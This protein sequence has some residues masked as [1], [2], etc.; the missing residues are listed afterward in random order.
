[1]GGG[2][3]LPDDP[4]GFATRG[5]PVRRGATLLF[6][7]GVD[8]VR[9]Q[10]RAS[11]PTA[12]SRPPDG[13]PGRGC[14]GDQVPGPDLG[15]DPGIGLWA[16]AR[17][18]WRATGTGGSW[19]ALRAGRG[20]GDAGPWL[21]EERGRHRQP[22]VS[23]RLHGL[24]GGRHWDPASATPSWASAA[25]G[26]KP[27]EAPDPSSESVV[28]VAGRSD[29]QIPPLIAALAPL[30]FLAPRVAA[31][32]PPGSPTYSAYLLPDLVAAHAPAR[33]LLAA[34]PAPPGSILAGLG[35]DWVGGPVVG[36]L[37][38]DGVARPGT[39]RWGSRTDAAYRRLDGPGPGSTN[40][41]ATWPR[42]RASV[43]RMLNPPSEPGS[44][45]RLPPG[46]PPVLLVGQAAVFHLNRP[47]V[48]NTVFDDETIETLARGRGPRAQVRRGPPRARRDRPRLRRLVRGRAGIGRRATTASPTFVTPERVR[49]P[50]GGED[51]RS[52]RATRLGLR[53]D[54]FIEVAA[55]AARLNGAATEGRMEDGFD[56]GDRRGGV[57][58]LDTSSNLLD[59]GAGS[60]SSCRRTSPSADVAHLPAGRRGRP[61]R[62]PR[63][64]ESFEKG[65][66]RGA[67][68]VY[69]LAANPNLW[70]RD[71]GEFAAVNHRGTVH[72]LDAAL[73]AGGV[74]RFVHVSTESIL[75][76]ARAGRPGRSTKG[77]RGRDRP[78]P[79]GPYCRSKLR[80]EDEAMARA[81]PRAPRW[82][83]VNPTMPVGP[84]DRGV[85]P[86]TRLI[87][88][89][90]ATVKLPARD[91]LHAE[92][93]RR[94]GRRPRLGPGHG[95]RARPGR[96]YLLGRGKPDADGRCS[97]SALGPH[98]G[99]RPAP[100]RS[101]TRSAWR[102]PYASEVL[103]RSTSVR[104]PPQGHRSPE[105]A[106]PGGRMDFD[107]SSQPPPNSAWSPGP[108]ASP[109]P[110]PWP[111]WKPRQEDRPDDRPKLIAA[112]AK[113]ANG[114]VRRGTGIPGSSVVFPGPRITCLVVLIGTM[115][116]PGL[117][118]DHDGRMRVVGA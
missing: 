16:I 89:F 51:R 69:H 117:Q 40:G 100:E 88:D 96:R 77:C 43:P 27:I 80:A 38:V 53:Q 22:G 1:M 78:T 23:A 104:P 64:G 98:R 5:Q 114:L 82:S 109:S 113:M 39:W 63:P 50:G 44:T 61:G 91:G 112:Q 75:T 32:R 48:Y 34:D 29:W 15:G 90:L 70:A 9:N 106:S 17:A 68:F 41:P 33:P 58:R 4:L 59:S 37:G 57:H 10:G 72:V 110:M 108:S 19:L 8:L 3:N 11:R 55:G 115:A 66:P 24:F 97:K 14:D 36:A 65:G 62:H 47:I 26:P 60:G 94:A 73:G 101:R 46:S 95:P 85:S 20:G 45:P 116:F 105:S 74:E 84:G 30:A 42:L 49:R 103:G 76:R 54:L 28:D 67:R 35:S 52:G 87:R 6:S 71:R 81:R 86:P 13:L 31:S 118:F 111:G 12:P 21:G 56:A 79:I 107:A 25:T 92:P 99:P 18:A 2:G 102:S 7:R 83:I 93:G